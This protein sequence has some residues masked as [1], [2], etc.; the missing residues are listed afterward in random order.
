MR[1][2]HGPD[3]YPDDDRHREAGIDVATAQVH[4][5]TGSGGNPDHEITGRRRNLERQAHGPI[6]GEHFDRA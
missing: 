4:A 6:Q 1:P 2:D 3:Q 5:R